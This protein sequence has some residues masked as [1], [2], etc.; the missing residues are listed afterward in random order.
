MLVALR[1]HPWGPILMAIVIAV[2]AHRSGAA[3][4]ADDNAVTENAWT[5]RWLG[6]SFVLVALGH[7]VVGILP[8]F[9]LRGVDT[10]RMLLPLQQVDCLTQQLSG[11]S[12]QMGSRP[13][14]LYVYFTVITPYLPLAAAMALRPRPMRPDLS[15]TSVTKH[16]FDDG[17]W[18]WRTIGLVSLG[19]FGSLYLTAQLRHC[20]VD[21]S[22]YEPW[23]T[24]FHS[25][26][27]VGFFSFFY[28]VPAV[29]GFLLSALLMAV[30]NL[31]AVR[32]L[33]NRLR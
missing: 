9:V 16:W 20:V 4:A 12:L 14:L 11:L 10:F 21:Q 32:G 17:S 22:G 26:A 18:R 19:I 2:W 13:G 24:D 23:M 3:H 7:G 15:P 28:L 1:L 25:A 6:L 30:G 8:D 31:I 5:V 29:S 27:K 33:P